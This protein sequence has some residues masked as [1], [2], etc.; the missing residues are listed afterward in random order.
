MIIQKE[1]LLI[2]DDTLES[3][4]LLANTLSEQGYKVRGAAKAQ[5]AIRTARLSPPDLILLDIKMPE[6]DGYEVCERLK[7]TQET[8]ISRSFLLVL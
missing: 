3:L 8:C 2:I 1:N 6:M 5:M 4:Q 7:S